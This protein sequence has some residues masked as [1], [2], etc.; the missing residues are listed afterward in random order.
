ML[1]EA[2]VVALI[3]K[4]D[5]LC[6]RYNTLCARKGSYEVFDA[7]YE[8]TKAETFFRFIPP[9]K[10]ELG[11]KILETPLSNYFWKIS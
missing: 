10:V 5:E 11:G 9:L 7:T 1:P 6:H 4:V 8:F 3:S 2:V